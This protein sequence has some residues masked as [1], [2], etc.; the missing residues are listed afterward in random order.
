[1]KYLSAV[2]NI[3]SPQTV[4][5]LYYK[6]VL[7]DI[8][9]ESSRLETLFAR[10]PPSSLRSESPP[11]SMQ[12]TIEVYFNYILLQIVFFLTVVWFKK[13]NHLNLP[14]GDNWEIPRRG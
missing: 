7:V 14:L 6:L 9:V 1:M 13:K 2:T 10:P 3:S 5:E 4:F 12:T 11:R 8:K